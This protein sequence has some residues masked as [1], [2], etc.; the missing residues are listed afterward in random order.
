MISGEKGS[1]LFEH[2]CS[3]GHAFSV[4]PPRRNAHC[5]LP[6]V[7]YKDCDLGIHSFKS[8]GIVLAT[9]IRTCVYKYFFDER[10][11]LVLIC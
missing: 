10:S 5:T 7:I 3:H 2:V 4:R 8:L 11:F 6:A 1:L 9:M